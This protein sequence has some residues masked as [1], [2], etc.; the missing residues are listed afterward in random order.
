MNKILAYGAVAL[1]LGALSACTDDNASNPTLKQPTEFVLNTPSYANQIIVLANRESLELTWSQPDYTD[2]GAPLAVTYQVQVSLTDSYTVSYDETQ[3]DDADPELVCDYTVIDKTVTTCTYDVAASDIS[4]ALQQLN[5]WTE[6]DVPAQTQAYVRVYAYIA[7]GTDVLYPNASNSLLLTFEPEYVE[8]SD[9]EPIMWYLVGNDIGDGSW[10]DNAGV[11]SF[12][13]FLQAGY[14]YD[15][16]TGGGEIIYLNYFEQYCNFKFQPADWDWDYGFMGDGANAAIYRNGDSDAGN[17][18][19]D[20]E[21]Y[22]LVTINTADNTCTIVKQDITPTDYGTICLSGSFNDWADTE[23]TP[24]HTTGENHVW[25]YVL[26]VAEGETEEV[27]FK[28][29]DSWDVNWGYGSDASEVKY[30]TGSLN[31]AN[32]QLAEGT[33]VIM[34]NDI[35]GDFSI[36]AK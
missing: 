27:K 5:E 31:A 28:I 11:S 30:G 35:T 7:E 23:M 12:P 24:V 3:A 13:F 16:K 29:A 10:S 33:W 2:L 19:T 26:T 18:W 6:D 34:F 15:K 17:I 22:F 4:K 20:E 25:A 21:G 9:A 8:L 36:V 14:S 32:I 1:A